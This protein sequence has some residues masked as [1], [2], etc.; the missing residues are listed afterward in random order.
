MQTLRL[1]VD[2]AR[3]RSFSQAAQRHGVTQSAASQRIGQLERRLGA[4]LLDRSV[5]PLA[6]TDAGRLFLGGCGEILGIYERLERKIEQLAGEANG[7]AAD[8]DGI[9]RVAA[10]YSAGIDLLNDL[11]ERFEADHPR[12]HIE[13]RY[14]KPDGV[15]QAVRDRDC[16]LG[17]LSYPGRWAK[18]GV[19]PLRDEPMA[20][21]CR[22]DHP[23]AGQASVHA[24]ELSGYDM[25]AFEPALPVSRA[26]RQY[27]RQHEASL[28]VRNEFDNIDTIKAAVSVTEQVAILPRRTVSREVAAGTLAMVELE[29]RLVR[30]MGIIFRAPKAGR[31]SSG[32][33][34]PDVTAHGDRNGAAPPAA[35][36]DEVRA[37]ADF[38]IDHAGPSVDRADQATADTRQP[39][40]ALA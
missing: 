32:N 14:H 27:L 18:V 9:V 10:I 22:P 7:H 39:V 40:G 8:L 2:V 1:F 6:L 25:A 29:P 33:G 17:I 12:L 4:M 38:L 23:L 13:V 31:A 21:V 16:D 34:A 24:A 36:T 5:R 28:K 26:I 37:F 19:L 30:P 35:F 20:V 3:C 15:Y 11:S